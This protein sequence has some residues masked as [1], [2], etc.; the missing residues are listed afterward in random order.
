MSSAPSAI[1]VIAV[2][3]GGTV[4]RHVNACAIVEA[5]SAAGYLIV[6]EAEL[7]QRYENG[8]D[9]GYADWILAI[10]EEF[11]LGDED[12]AGPKDFLRRLKERY[13]LVQRADVI[14]PP[15]PD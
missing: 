13:S 14:A 3:L 12:I 8:E 6:G 9:S 15:A 10:T 5:L 2:A 1:D 7:S 4:S 11:E